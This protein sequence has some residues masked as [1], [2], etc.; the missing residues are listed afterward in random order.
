MRLG[1]LHR[2]NDNIAGALE[3]YQSALFIRNNICEPFE[4]YVN[5]LQQFLFANNCNIILFGL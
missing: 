2:F 4:T 5:L 1:D 3:E